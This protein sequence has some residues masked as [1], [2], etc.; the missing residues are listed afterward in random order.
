[1]CDGQPYRSHCRQ[2][3]DQTNGYFSW[4]S[5][6]Q[7]LVLKFNI[8]AS[9]YS[10]L[11]Q[12]KYK[13]TPSWYLPVLQPKMKNDMRFANQFTE[14]RGKIYF[15]CQ[16]KINF[17]LSV[18]ET[19]LVRMMDDGR[20]DEDVCQHNTLSAELV[21]EGRPVS[22]VIN[23]SSLQCCNSIWAQERGKKEVIV[24]RSSWVLV[25]PLEPQTHC[26]LFRLVRI[27]LSC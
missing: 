21:T 3:K 8:K 5:A 7:C 26:Q 16:K 1:M 19:A 25:L 6:P 14:Y 12:D 23:D 20:F 9:V 24:T 18:M 27:L 15:S 11:L 4:F 13:I 10:L 2:R 22:R 17:F